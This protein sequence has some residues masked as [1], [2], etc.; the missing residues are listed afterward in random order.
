M[1]DFVAQKLEEFGIQVN[2]GIGKTG[3][4]GVLQWGMKH[5]L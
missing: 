4:V 5:V 3:L 2:R 1:A